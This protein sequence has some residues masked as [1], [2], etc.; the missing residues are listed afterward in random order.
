M[1]HVQTARP[2]CTST[3]PIPASLARCRPAHRV[4]SCCHGAA[5]QSESLTTVLAIRLLTCTS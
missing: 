4:R 5:I 3:M 2:R 1:P